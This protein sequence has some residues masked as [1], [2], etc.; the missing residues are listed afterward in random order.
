MADAAGDIIGSFD[1]DGRES[2]E[3]DESEQKEIPPKYRDNRE[4]EFKQ[5][6]SRKIKVCEVYRDSEGHE[7]EEPEQELRLSCAGVELFVINGIRRKALRTMNV[8]NAELFKEGKTEGGDPIQHALLGGAIGAQGAAGS[9]KGMVIGMMATPK[10]R[11]IWY[12]RIFEYDG[13]VHIYR[14]NDKHSGE[15]VI[16]FLDMCALV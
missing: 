6:V 10:S 14:L 2:S 5:F 13:S 7:C 3:H 1:N 16:N 9:L 15:E 12:L 11:D 4:V 8:R